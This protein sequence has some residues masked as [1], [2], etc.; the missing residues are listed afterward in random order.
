MIS[1]KILINCS[2]FLFESFFHRKIRMK[3]ARECQ[4]QC[5]VCLRI[6]LPSSKW[7][8]NIV[9]Y[10]FTTRMDDNSSWVPF[11]PSLLTLIIV[12]YTRMTY[13]TQTVLNESSDPFLLCSTQ[14]LHVDADNIQQSCD[15]TYWKRCHR[16][17]WQKKEEYL[18]IHD[19]GKKIY[20]KSFMLLTHPP[21]FVVWEMKKRK[22]SNDEFAQLLV[23]D[24]HI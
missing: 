19:M 10:I 4:Q 18:N 12:N 15:R 13:Y 14:S 6:F 22:V 21:A 1:K 7:A 11:F 5:K 20:M 3:N 17:K 23:F 9:V 24:F 8:S 16:I 2:L